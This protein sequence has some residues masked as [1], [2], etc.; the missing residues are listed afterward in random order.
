M[1]QEDDKFYASVV[2]IRCNSAAQ[3]DLA[4]LSPQDQ[5]EIFKKLL[6]GGDNKNWIQLIGR[7]LI[8]V[9]VSTETYPN[10]SIMMAFRGN[11]IEIVQVL[12]DDSVRHVKNTHSGKHDHFCCINII[13]A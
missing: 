8:R 10:V 4:V 9:F 5:E 7:N 13:V 11:Y 3:Q 12:S 2:G 1:G 6:A